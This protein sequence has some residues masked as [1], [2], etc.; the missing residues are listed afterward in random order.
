M[1]GNVIVDNDT[2]N[3]YKLNKPSQ[4]LNAMTSF[5]AKYTVAKIASRE[6]GNI[7]HSQQFMF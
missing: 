1:P 6:G 3:S 7:K 5:L 4:E 2:D